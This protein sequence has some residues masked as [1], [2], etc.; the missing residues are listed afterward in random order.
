MYHFHME[1]LPSRIR[2]K[3]NISYEI[4]YQDVIKG[5][6]DCLGMCDPNTRHIYIKTGISKTDLKK[7]IIHE[8]FH[9]WESEYEIKISH[10]SIYKLEDAVLK[11]LTLNK[12]I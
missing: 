1:E 3:R 8:L 9:C 12:I 6:E 5:D 2:I 10:E 7:T 4:V 11:F